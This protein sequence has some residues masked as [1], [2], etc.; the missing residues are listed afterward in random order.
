M[1]SNELGFD[2]QKAIVSELR[3][4]HKWSNMVFLSNPVQYSCEGCGFRSTDRSV[5]CRTLEIADRLE[6]WENY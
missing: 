1:S 3:A 5:K 4:M 6:W 2:E